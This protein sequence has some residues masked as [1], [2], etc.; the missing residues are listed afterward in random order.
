M[1]EH[2]LRKLLIS[3]RL[4]RFCSDRAKEITSRSIKKAT[5]GAAVSGKKN[6]QP[7]AIKL[8]FRT[9]ISASS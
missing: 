5:D 3:P 1:L 6:G 4:S 8:S 2:K 7:D 9:L